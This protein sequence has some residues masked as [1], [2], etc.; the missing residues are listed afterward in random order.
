MTWPTG[1]VCTMASTGNRPV[2]AL[3]FGLLLG[4]SIVPAGAEGKTKR[5]AEAGA[6][7]TEKATQ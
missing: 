4:A 6:A 3:A 5:T 2:A 1:P 7:A